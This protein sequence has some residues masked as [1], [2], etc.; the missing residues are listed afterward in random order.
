MRA[1]IIDR[2]SRISIFRDVATDSN[3]LK[4]I[5]DRL[6]RQE[7]KAGST[8]ISEGEDGDELFIL[9]SGS[10]RI[11]RK[12]L[13]EEQYALV[14]LNA[15]GNVF[16]GEVALIDNDK[17]SASVMAIT[18]CETLNLSRKNYLELCEDDPYLG[19]K[20]TFQIALRL[21]ASLRKSSKDMI[22][23]YQALL[24]EIS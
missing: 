4:K 1:D 20:I 16:F 13:S 3:R 9:N 15:E 14:N 2:I 8:I 18:D 22:T 17:R 24:E 23:M 19:F 6:E 21:G 7:H 10:V 11:L 5:A 12:T